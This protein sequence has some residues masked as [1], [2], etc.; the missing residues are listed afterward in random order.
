MRRPSTE[1]EIVPCKTLLSSNG[2][3]EIAVVVCNY[4]GDAFSPTTEN[5]EDSF[6]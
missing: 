3:P 1:E 5:I 6:C 2:H 4:V